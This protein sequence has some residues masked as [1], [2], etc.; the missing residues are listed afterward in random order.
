MALQ[1]I[2]IGASP[3]DGSGD[4]LRTAMD[5]IN[6]NF[7]A[8]SG[9]VFNVKDPAYGAVGDGVTD[10]Y[11]AIQAAIDAMSDYDTLYIPAGAFAVSQKLVSDTARYIKVRCDGWIEPHGSYSDFLI[12]FMR[13]STS[14]GI[15]DRSNGMIL[16]SLRLRCFGQCRGVQLWNQD[17]STFGPIEVE[18]PYGTGIE[19]RQVREGT[20]I[21]ASVHTGKHRVVFTHGS[22]DP[23]DNSTTWNVNEIVYIDYDDWSN[24]TTYAVN[25]YVTGTDGNPYRSIQASNLNKDPTQAANRAW[26]RRVNFEYYKCLIQHSNKHP[27]SFHTN[28]SSAGDRYWQFVWDH[29][30]AGDI[31]ENN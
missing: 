24:A 25:D 22:T 5:K 15:A 27:E 10:N 8:V 12:Q 9:N 20:F 14:N 4:P 2:N 1:T 16:D 11:A 31:D 29:E 30:A 3:N 21:K 6:D 23:W 26:W 28:A 18:R 17:V 13:P 7:L 19:I